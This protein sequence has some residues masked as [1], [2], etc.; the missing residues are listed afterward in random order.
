M[1]NDKNF[2]QVFDKFSSRIKNQDKGHMREI[3]IQEDLLAD[4]LPNLLPSRQA[5]DLGC[6]LGDMTVW[7]ARQGFLGEGIDISAKM[8]EASQERV[9][10][11]QLAEQIKI[12]QASLWDVID[13][14]KAPHYDLVCLHAV[15]EWLAEPY[16]VPGKLL[17]LIK[18]GGFLSLT[19][20]N[21]HRSVFD[22]LIKGNFSRIV[23]E[24]NFS[25]RHNSLTPPNPIIPEQIL[26]KLTEAGFEIIRFSG[27]RCF[28]DYFAKESEPEQSLEDLLILERRY[29]NQSPFREIARYIHIIARRKI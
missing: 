12:R 11:E 20:Y 7:L 5:L 22:S 29:R 23:Q 14:E 15:L 26:A 21:R 6:G 27:L 2:D 1:V 24:D 16:Q 3:L 17:S 19:L 8:V 9:L 13:G 18:P 10:A 28:Y 25:G 4:V